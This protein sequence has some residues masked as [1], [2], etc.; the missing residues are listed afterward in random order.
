MRQRLVPAAVALLL[1]ACTGAAPDPVQSD[2]LAAITKATSP[3]ALATASTT[4]QLADLAIPGLRAPV[5][6]AG[7]VVGPVGASGP[8]PLVVLL[9]GYFPSCWRQSDGSATTDWPC[10]EGFEPIP[11]RDGFTYLQERLAS[12]GYLTVSL[13]ANGVNVMATSMGEDAGAA[14][15]SRLVRHHL[16]AWA[17]GEVPGV[18]QWPAVDA[19]SVLLVGH[20]R[21]GEGVDR[22]ALD[23][24]SDAAWTVR[25]EVLIAPTGFRASDR[26]VVPVVAMTG[27]CDGDTGP[28]PAQWYV[29]RPADPALLR[30]AVIIEGANHNFFNTQ[31][32]PS[33]S[34]LPGGADDAFDEAGEVDPLC[35]PKGS[36]RLSGAEQREV[37]SRIVGLAA[38]ALL[39]DDDAAA[40]VLDGRI[41]VPAAGSEQ[42]RVSATGRGRTTLSYDDGFTGS[43]EGPVE[44][45]VCDGVSETEEADDCGRF[46]GEGR[47]VHWPGASRGPAAAEFLELAWAEVGGAVRLALR[48]PLDLSRAVGLEARIAAESQPPG[49][50]AP[51]AFDVVLV[52]AAG[53]AVTVP[54]GGEVATFAE[55]ERLPAR[56][57]GQRLLVPLAEVSGIDLRNV[58]E[59]RLVPRSAPGHA[60]IIDLS[61]LPTDPPVGSL[62]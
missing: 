36:A 27:Y 37:A 52:D 17:A 30:S 25:G 1:T 3:G 29:D 56:R 46:S 40:D 54:E 43:G 47:S 5:E 58:V 22:A 33:A 38:A 45:E 32:D 48:E 55:G 10:R 21:G 24:T 41:A 28:G 15:R 62:P 6:V 23:R 19:S 9:H 35:D 44:V 42:V 26:G 20:S 18:A 50:G 51:V 16:D 2:P 14:A 31:W 13:S 11:N 7:R 49:A 60:W 39:R 8:L 57:W 59:V 61:A 4:Y 12:Q 53:T 34:I